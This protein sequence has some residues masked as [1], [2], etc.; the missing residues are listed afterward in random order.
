MHLTQKMHPLPKIEREYEKKKPSSSLHSSL[1]LETF[2]QINANNAVHCHHFGGKEWWWTPNADYWGVLQPFYVVFLPISRTHTHIFC[3]YRF[4]A[5]PTGESVTRLLLNILI[6]HSC[7][8]RIISLHF[9]AMLIGRILAAVRAFFPSII[10]P[11]QKT[12]GEKSNKLWRN[13]N[14]DVVMVV[15]FSWY[16]WC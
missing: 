7:F 12:I 4:H 9:F 6:F 1:L 16:Y 3:V 5:N 11:R 10:I 2:V 13:A 14:I 15:Y 8:S